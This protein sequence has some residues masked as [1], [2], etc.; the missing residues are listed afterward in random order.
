MYTP[1]SEITIAYT[2]SNDVPVMYSTF[3]SSKCGPT[4]KSRK[5]KYVCRYASLNRDI[6]GT[7]DPMIWTLN[8]LRMRDI[9]LGA[10]DEY[11]ANHNN[12]PT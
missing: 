11:L 5:L 3:E 9:V 8:T 2:L 7:V 1:Q 4:P 12:A 10:P 6:Y